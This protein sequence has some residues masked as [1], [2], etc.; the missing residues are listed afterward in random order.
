M[1]SKF[2]AVLLCSFFSLGKDSKMGQTDLFKADFRFSQ[3]L[4][5]SANSVLWWLQQVN[6]GE[7]PTA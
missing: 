1:V 7:M 6:V 5:I 3:W 2:F 4:S